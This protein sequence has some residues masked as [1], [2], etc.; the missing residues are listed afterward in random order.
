MLK[1]IFEAINK[2]VPGGYPNNKAD[3][4]RVKRAASFPTNPQPVVFLMQHLDPEIH[5]P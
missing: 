5:Q 4:R 1:H 2:H 3:I